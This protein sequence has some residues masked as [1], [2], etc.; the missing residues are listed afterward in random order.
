MEQALAPLLL[1]PDVLDRCR[2]FR[3]R[4]FTPTVVMRCNATNASVSR[5]ASVYNRVS[6]CTHQ[7]FVH[8]QKYLSSWP[9]TTVC[10]R[11][12]APF[13]P[14]EHRSADQ[15]S[16]LARSPQFVQQMQA[17]SAALTSGQL[18]LRQFGLQVSRGP[19][20][21]IARYVVVH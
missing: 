12:L 1:H 7:H 20:A 2:S 16:A 14:E 5:L 11:R 6:L 21:V 4:R 8:V 17:L 15:L 3:Y 13:M 10:H 18:D 19:H 9:S